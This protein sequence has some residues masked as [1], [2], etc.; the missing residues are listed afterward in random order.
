MMLAAFQEAALVEEDTS[1]P[2]APCWAP[3][4]H[5]CLWS[6]SHDG[7]AA[8]MA[9]TPPACTRPADRRTLPSWCA[10]STT[11]L[12]CTCARVACTASSASSSTL[13]AACWPPCSGWHCPPS[14]FCSTWAC[15]CSYGCST[16]CP[17]SCCSWATGAWILGSW[18]TWLYTACRSPCS[19]SEALAGA[20]WCLWTC[21]HYDTSC[22]WIWM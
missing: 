10:P 5:P 22:R 18:T 8:S 6:P 2:S 4:A 1:N 9:P 12:T 11:T 20:S 15:A 16:S 13:A 14:S 3:V 7:C 17:L 21:S 19:W